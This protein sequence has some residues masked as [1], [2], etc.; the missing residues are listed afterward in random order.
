MTR[1]LSVLGLLAAG[2]ALL[3]GDD[4]KSNDDQKAAKIRVVS[5]SIYNAPPPKPGTFMAVPN[6]LNM[7]V[8]VSLPGRFIIGVDAKGSQLE[9]FTDDKDHVLFKKGGGL[10]GTETHWILEHFMRFNPDGEAVTVT[11]RGTDPPG[12]GAE[13]ILLKG[14]LNVLCGADEK[15]ADAKE[16]AMKPKQ[17]AEVGPFKV[18]VG[19]FGNAVEVLSDKENLKNVEFLDTNGKA[20]VTGLPTRSH[21]QSGRGKTS[22]HYNYFLAGKHE[23]FTVKIHYC[24]K[25]E[26]VKVPLDL[27]VGL[28]L[29]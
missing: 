5:L 23:K 10:F 9:R 11:I 14:S 1:W 21:T 17:E 7:D 16:V 20:I 18:R 2:A 27:R 3:A 25:V 8:M 15:V 12:K 4:K 6:G 29:E 28:S 19:P 24:T 22:H 13:K 26:T